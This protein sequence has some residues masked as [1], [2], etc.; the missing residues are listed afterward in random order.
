MVSLPGMGLVLETDIGST[1]PGTGELLRIV[2]ASGNPNTGGLDDSGVLQIGSEQ[3]SYSSKN[4]NGVI[5]SS[6]EYGGTT[7]AIHNKN[8]AVYV[9]ADGIATD[10]PPISRIEL[11]WNGSIVGKDYVMWTSKLPTDPR[12]PGAANWADDWEGFNTVTGNSANPQI[13]YISPTERIKHILIVFQQ[14]STDPARARMA[15]LR[16]ILD[17]T[18]YGADAALPADTVAGDLLEQ[19]LLNAGIPLA[20]ISHSGTVAL[21]QV[22][23]AA[24]SAWL[25]ISDYADYAGLKINVARDSKISITPSTLWSAAQTTIFTWDRSSAQKIK[26]TWTNGE[27]I[28]QVV[29]PWRAPSG[30][31][32]GTER[33]PAEQTAIGSPYEFD[34]TLFS[35]AAAAAIAAQRRYYVLRYPAT[36]LI[37]S[38]AQHITMRPGEIHKVNWQTTFDHSTLNR[39]YIVTKADHHVEKRILTTAVELQQIEHEDNT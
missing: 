12:S 35:S 38:A 7:A 6:R 20:A 36:V 24:D 37:D 33:Y 3:I 39:P 4:E 1:T 16:A 23:T 27:S 13:N 11:A 28:S 14:M 31:A 32:D 17:E 25:V 19:V 10:A 9:V 8:D 26:K 22:Q 29:L 2:D 30:E 18:K 34:E 21:D 15:E 5:V